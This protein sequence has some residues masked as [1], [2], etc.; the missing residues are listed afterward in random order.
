MK[1]TWNWSFTFAT[2]CLSMAA[3]LFTGTRAT[4]APISADVF[5]TGTDQTLSANVFAT[6]QVVSQGSGDLFGSPFVINP[7]PQSD[8]VGLDPDTISLNSNPVSLTDDGVPA[9]GTGPPTPVTTQFTFDDATWETLDISNLHVDLLNGQSVSAA[10]D[11]IYIEIGLFPPLNLPGT[12]DVDALLFLDELSFW[13]DSGQSVTIDSATGAFTVP[14]TVRAVFD[15]TISA[16]GGS[17][18][19]LVLIDETQEF[20]LDLVGTI[21]TTAQ[22]GPD[23]QDVLLELDGAFDIA[24]PL[25]M[26]LVGSAGAAGLSI[27]GSIDLAASVVVDLNYHLEYL[28]ADVHSEPTGLLGDI[29]GDGEVDI[30]DFTLWADAF[31]DTGVGLPEDISGDGEVDIGDFTIWADNFGN[32]AGAGG[33][34]GVSAVP[35][36]SSVVLLGL[37]I[38]GVLAYTVRR[39]RTR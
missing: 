10:I 6:G 26:A 32:T 11:T 21:T 14:G 23:P 39:R 20:P 36:P 8:I 15:A 38:V 22:G 18:E 3:C 34:G 12:V 37:G 29:S 1:F 27:D 13:Q 33:G 2:V 24:A 30:G 19:A 31:G 4:A 25:D 35:E 7:S 9:G 17:V 16:L 5:F 28:L